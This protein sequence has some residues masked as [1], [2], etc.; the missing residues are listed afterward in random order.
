M[1]QKYLL[2]VLLAAVVFLTGHIGQQPTGV[3]AG[4]G[5]IIKS[6]SPDFTEVRSGEE[7]SLLLSM[8][9]V[10]EAEATG[11]S[12][13]LF[14]LNFGANDWSKTSGNLVTKLPTT[15]RGANPSA[16]LPGDIF[17]VTW[18]A[19]APLNL[20][21]D[22][23][24]TADTRVHFIYKTTSV[25]TIR[26][27]TNDYIKS[28]PTQQAEQVRKTAGVISSKVSGAPVQLTATVGARPLIV[29]QG[30]EVY[31]LSTVV[32]NVGSGNAFKDTAGY[33]GKT[34]SYDVV[35]TADMLT[36]DNLHLVKVNI[37]T[38]ANIN[39]KPGFE[40]TLNPTAKSGYV[41]LSR[42]KSKTI[43]CSI[44]AP[45]PADLGNTKDFTVN[46]EL[47]YGYFVDSST[48]IKVLK[49]EV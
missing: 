5:V 49:K 29:Y 12:A 10:G 7:I 18:G 28:L 44:T 45:A 15:L 21:V 43:S 11:V 36:T 31:T 40:S 35:P 41:K 16:N 42:G 32:S 20:R 3:A 26:F 48:S 38:D 13:Q 24:Y 30:G 14:G 27:V 47:S 6:F 4:N 25:S 17:D 37:T 19:K 46:A 1:M 33:P 9:N 22:N 23:T 39:C 2:I 34:A 8:D